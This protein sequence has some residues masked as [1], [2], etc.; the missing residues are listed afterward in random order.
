MIMIG[1]LAVP[2][3]VLSGLDRGFALYLTR[4]RGF[5]PTLTGR[6]ITWLEG[7]Q[8]LQQSPWVG[9]GFW[10]DRLFVHGSNMQSTFFDALIQVGFLGFAPFLIALVWVWVGILR[11][12]STKPAGETTSL[13]GELLAAMTFFTVYSITEITFSFYSVGWMAMAPLFAHVQW[14]VCQSARQRQFTRV[15]HVTP[16]PLPLRVPRRIHTV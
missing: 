6:T 13:P 5:D 7:W 2:L 14:R 1:L 4:A 3:V 16:W 10:G 12:Y 8:V 9:L 11:F 15:P